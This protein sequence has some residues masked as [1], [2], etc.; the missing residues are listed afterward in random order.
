MK[1]LEEHQKGTDCDWRKGFNG[2]EESPLLFQCDLI[3]WNDLATNRSVEN[4]YRVT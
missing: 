4:I 3:L 1:R 2:R